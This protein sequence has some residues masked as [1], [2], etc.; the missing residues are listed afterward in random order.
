MGRKASTPGGR[1]TPGQRPSKWGTT[2]IVNRTP[3]STTTTVV[4]HW[5]IRRAG[6]TLETA[7]FFTDSLWTRRPIRTLIEVK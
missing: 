2:H 4:I 3:I 7:P 6:R 5:M 1:D